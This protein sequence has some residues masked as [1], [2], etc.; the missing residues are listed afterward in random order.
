MNVVSLS[1]KVKPKLL[2]FFFFFFYDNRLFKKYGR[3]IERSVLNILFRHI[4]NSG[5]TI[6]NQ[7]EKQR[8]GKH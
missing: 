3:A 1:G 5:Q 6:D 7:T 2:M 4:S 8:A